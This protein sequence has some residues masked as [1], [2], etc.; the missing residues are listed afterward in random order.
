MRT[1]TVLFLALIANMAQADAWG[2]CRNTLKAEGAVFSTD[3]SVSGITLSQ[4]LA[5]L[6]AEPTIGE[7]PVV[8]I[9]FEN[10]QRAVLD[11]SN[12]VFVSRWMI[13]DDLMNVDRADI[14]SYFTLDKQGISLIREQDGCQRLGIVTT[15][16]ETRINN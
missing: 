7:E 3:S 2:D 9:M 8:T 5:G 13:V 14:G 6:S 10:G 11:E 15:W 1:V 16:P 4:T 12:T